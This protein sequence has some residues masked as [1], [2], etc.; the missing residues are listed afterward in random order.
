MWKEFGKIVLAM[1]SVTSV[2]NARAQEAVDC[3]SKVTRTNL[4]TCAMTASLSIRGEQ[5]TAAALEGRRTASGLILPSNPVLSLW[6][7]RR[8]GS[9]TEP[10]TLNWSASLSQEI[11]VA[12]QRASRLRAADAALLAQEKRVLLTKRE[13][14]VLAWSAFFEALAAREQQRLAERLLSTSERMGVVARARAEKGVGA[15]L[16]ADLADAATLRL[17][18]IKLAADRSVTTSVAHLRFVLGQSPS[19][20]AEVEGDLLPLAGIPDARPA[21]LSER[22]E[23]Q[24]ADAERNA[25]LERAEAFRRSRVP[26]PTVSVIVQND[27]Y[28]ERVFGLGLSIP[29]PL[30]APVGR[31]YA[32]EIAEADALSQRAAIDRTRVERELQLLI[33]DTYATY[34]AHKKAALAMTPERMRRAEDS[35]RDLQTEIEA[36]RLGVRDALVAQQT[37]IELLQASIAE[38]RSFCLAS[39]DLAHAL[40][41]PLD[42]GAR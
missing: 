42:G 24:V 13:T 1:A 38:R 28:N 37:L 17:L 7:G 30:P 27:G 36:G 26:N 22:P 9:A 14:A 18:Q 23:V 16:D 35:L 20:G 12:G 32:G 11:E 21:S 3:A 8:N 29:I 6:G 40:G 33:A 39:V 41:L 15:V 31:T 5:K 19:V 2:S 25:M 10:T 34:A 4:V